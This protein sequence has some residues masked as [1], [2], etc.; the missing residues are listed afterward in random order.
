[1]TGQSQDVTLSSSHLRPQ[2]ATNNGYEQPD[3]VES[4]FSSTFPPDSTLAA[5]SDAID[6]LL[7]PSSSLRVSV[8]KRNLLEKRRSLNTHR[9]HKHR[10]SGAFLLA[11]P[12]SS[13]HVHPRDRD[14][15]HPERRHSHRK[16]LDPYKEHESSYQ[17]AYSSGSQVPGPGVGYTSRVSDHG[18]LLP[19][20]PTKTRR[21]RDSLAG[22]T[23]VGSSP[24]SSIAQLDIESA[25]I[26][27]MAL[28]LS[29]SRRLA[30][31]RNITQPTPPRLAPLPDTITGGSLR[32]HL[33][34][35][36]RM[37]RTVSPKPDRSPRVTA[38]RVFSPLQPSLEPEGSY[39]YHFSQSTLARAQKAKE[40]L[41]LMSQYRRVLEFL[42]PLEVSRTTKSLTASPPRT[43]NDSAQV[44]RLS[45]NDSDKTK[46]G[47]P[48]NP[49]QYIRNRKVRA[50][51][52]KAIDGAGQGF[53][54]VIKVSEWVDDVA[55][56]VATGQYRTPGNPVL[57]PFPG[58]ASAL[59]AS[60]PSNSSRVAVATTKPKRPRVDWVIDPADMIADIYWLE[61]GDNKKLIEDRHW[62]RLFPQGSD[63]TRPLSHDDMPRI[64]TPSSIKDSSEGLASSDK[65]QVELPPSKPE[66]EHVLSTAKGRAQQKLRA[67]KGSSHSRQSSTVTNR[68]FLRIHRGSLSESSDTD[69]DR[70]RRLRSV[71]EKQMEEMIEKEQ[72]ELELQA[73]YDHAALRMKF[74]S[75]SPNAS[76]GDLPYTSTETSNTRSHRRK[77][78]RVELSEPEGKLAGHK[79]RPAPSQP[80]ARASLEVPSRG[81]RFSVDY[82][83]SQPNSPVMRPSRD[84][85]LLPVIGMDL[86]PFSSRPSSPTRNPLSKVKGIFRDRSKDRERERERVPDTYASVE[87]IDSP[88]PLANNQVGS[89]ETDWSAVS[90]PDRRV[91]RS[92]LG[93]IVTRGTDSTHRSHKSSGSVKLRPE[94]VSGGLR[95]LFRGPRI[96]TILRSGVSKIGDLVWRRES[97]GAD[98]HSSSTS[99]DESED[100]ARGRSRGPRVIRR[101][102]GR[103]ASAQNG[104][105][106][107]E[108]TPELPKFVSTTDYATSPDGK[109]TAHPPAQPLSRRS[110]RFELLK[111]PRI[112]VHNASPSQSPPPLVE[113]Q[114]ELGSDAE[115]RKVSDAGKDG[116]QPTESITHTT[117]THDKP[118]QFSSASSARHWS[119]AN[120]GSGAP[121]PTSTISKR[122]IARLRALLLSSGIQAMEMDRRA[123]EPLPSSSCRKPPP[124]DLLR[125]CPQPTSQ[126]TLY[127]VAA[128]ALAGSIE[129]SATEFDAISYRFAYEKASALEKRVEEL[130]L[131]LAGE[132]TD[133]THGATDQA[134]E[135]NHDLVSGQR[136]KVKR[137]VDVI[138]KMLRRRRRRFR[139]VRRAGWLGVEWVLVGFMWCVWFVVMITRVFLGIGNGVIGFIRWLLWL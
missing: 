34:Q 73:P 25:Q 45:T 136:L 81:R 51:E 50:R 61:L 127:P 69:S 131:K 36:R 2:R 82:E 111:P 14:A 21:E 102:N 20:T 118:R 4:S 41:E 98:D 90:S 24:G 48:Y 108:A 116:I 38:G 113:R 62:R 42:P 103:D 12:L 76:G 134:D 17:R 71:L 93:R 133:L 124:T 104:K 99:S 129:A 7:K 70:R 49:L 74:A 58:A 35:Q 33:Q 135:A 72:K 32:Q 87:D 5:S 122:E 30:S 138:D 92:P 9:A 75:I 95:S 101:G 100:E 26:V 15:H 105:G 1:M 88:A 66:H 6:P 68:D 94:D 130:R 19:A 85:G 27:N 43:P 128:R 11:D 123:K 39:R 64:T 110:S 126:T 115:S 109:L 10:S 78:S 16:S 80:S 121:I 55:K 106:S 23:A 13:T 125:F 22:D 107:L 91:S 31:R 54:E 37:S 119:I 112:D 56:W 117:L 77:D 52:R 44:F 132:L 79:Q 28:N 65:A 114:R 59:Q 137:V 18:E 96:D 139:W 67:L 29:E 97:G 83:S 53:N 89:P 60:P 120:R 8:P 57:P 86:S 84:G 46:V 40:Y 63:S 3:G 47:R